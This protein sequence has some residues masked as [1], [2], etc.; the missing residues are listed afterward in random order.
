M[1]RL[2][3]TSEAKVRSDLL[4]RRFVVSRQRSPS[5]QSAQN[6]RK[7]QL[8]WRR[9]TR[10]HSTSQTWSTS[11]EM[12]SGEGEKPKSG[13]KLR[14]GRNR[15][16]ILS[17]VIHWELKPTQQPD[18]TTLKRKHLKTKALPAAVRQENLTISEP[19]TWSENRNINPSPRETLSHV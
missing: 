15:K 3:K 6:R 12:Q 5:I 10:H 13:E 2:S 14:V 9:S 4:E 7:N 11:S 16:S 17:R 1:D 18:L 19:Q 8:E